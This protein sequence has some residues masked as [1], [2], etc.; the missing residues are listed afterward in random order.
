MSE[1]IKCL[2]VRQPWAWALV[3][4]TKDIENRSWT[5]D[6]RGPIVIQASGSKAI[7]NHVI[8]SSTVPLP[9]MNFDYGA[10]IGVVDLL[11]VV[12]LSESLESNPWAWGPYCWKVGNAR[13]F[14][15]PIPA[16]G[17]L[18]LYA[19]ASDLADR[20]RAAITEAGAVRPDSTA[21]AWIKAITQFGNDERSRNDGL[22]DS[23]V[24]LNDNSNY[25]RLAEHAV[26]RWGD[27]MTFLDRGIAKQVNGDL[28]GALADV[29]HGI[30]MEPGAARGYMMR[31]HVYDALADSDRVKVNKIDPEYAVACGVTE[32]ADE[33]D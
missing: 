25:L 30:D 24:E 13:R 29:N 2:V 14:A 22:M 20:A 4:G 17:K 18:K 32:E 16:K 12:P 23:Y 19:L 27:A 15:K 5:T 10:L 8:N 21:E 11:D 31:S 26:S 6:Y 7:V 1:A 28:T 33:G 3:A 9:P